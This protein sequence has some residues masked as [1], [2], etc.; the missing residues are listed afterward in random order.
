MAVTVNQ[1]EDYIETTDQPVAPLLATAYHLVNSYIGSVTIPEEVKDQAVLQLTQE[2]SYRQ[3]SP[4]G[5]VNYTGEDTVV[6]LSKDP[7]SA[8][9][10]LLNKYVWG[11]G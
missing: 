1:A 2:L 7:M 10:P 4:G 6:R 3:R 5:I 9:Y 11:I 8:I